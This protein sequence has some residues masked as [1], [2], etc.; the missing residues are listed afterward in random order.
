MPRNKLP[1]R[2]VAE[3][4]LKGWTPG[5]VRIAVA[6][7]SEVMATPLKGPVGEGYQL[8]VELVKWL[9]Y[10]IKDD[11]KGFTEQ[12]DCYRP[13]GPASSSWEKLEELLDN[14]QPLDDLI[15]SLRRCHGDVVPV[16]SS[17]LDI[18]TEGDEQWEHLDRPH[19]RAVEVLAALG[20]P[21][22]LGYLLVHVSFLCAEKS[23][24]LHTLMAPHRATIDDVAVSVFEE[25]PWRNRG[26]VV[27]V[28][29]DYDIPRP[30]FTERILAVNGDAL[31]HADRREF[32]ECLSITGDLRAVPIV[33]RLIDRA[34]DE[35][36]SRPNDDA[37]KFVSSA[38]HMLVREL[39]STLT[40]EQVERAAR[41]GL[42]L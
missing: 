2:D 29:D 41:L 7:L 42:D 11:L 20:T 35:V 28:F 40:A 10:A 38:T 37:V 22:S 17:L 33:R 36:A 31:D 5:S 39:E 27:C 4:Q 8:A 15:A 3:V 24:P 12:L 6:A 30:R 16:L 25:I 18:A 1:E 13:S 23:S 32:V 34:L 21:E 19:Q 9:S 26:T 14:D